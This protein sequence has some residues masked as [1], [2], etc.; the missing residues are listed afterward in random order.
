MPTSLNLDRVIERLREAHTQLAVVV[1]EY[2]GT[3]G[4]ITAEDLAEEWSA[5]SPTSTTRRTSP[6]PA[7]APWAAGG[8][9]RLSGLLRADEVE[10]ACGW[11]MPEGDY[12]TLAGLV[13]ARLGHVPYV[14]EEVDV[15][16]RRLT[17][18]AM[19][20]LR[21]DEVEVAPLP[22]T[23]DAARDGVR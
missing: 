14:G 20:K 12:S 3:A 8:A 6:A 19:D 17:V 18:T 9:A 2:G 5:T 1:D 10:E 22:D 16:D 23:A 11:R 4:V 15:D 7:P 13:L 21:V